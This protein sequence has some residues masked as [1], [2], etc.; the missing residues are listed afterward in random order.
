MSL[1]DIDDL[2]GAIREIARVLLPAG[3]LCVAMVHPFASAQD[4]AAMH[5][6]LTVVRQ[7]YLVERRYEDHMERDGLRMSFISMHRPLSVYV[8]ACS[9]AGLALTALREFGNKSIP[10]L[11]SARFEKIAS[12]PR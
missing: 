5:T 7:P 11:L 8:S 6:Q 10:W 2:T 9:G 12:A 1:H 3:H 4:P